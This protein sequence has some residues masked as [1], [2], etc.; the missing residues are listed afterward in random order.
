MEAHPEVGFTYGRTIKTATPSWRNHAGTADWTWR[1]MSGAEWLEFRCGEGDNCVSTPTAVARTGL[2]KRIGG[3]R[4]ELPHTGDMEM[5]LRFALHADVGIINADQ[6]FYRT[7]GQSMSKHYLGLAGFE[8]RKA[9][10]DILLAEYGDAMKGF[11]RLHASAMRRIAEDAFWRANEAFESNDPVACRDFLAFA[12]RTY[13]RL[14]PG[15]I[16]RLRLK[17]LLGP[18]T[19]SALRPLLHRVYARRGAHAGAAR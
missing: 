4:K 3:Y 11:V 14:S 7:H 16:R 17:Q 18:K 13:P 9:V 15:L 1:I 2:Q 12:R 19:W 6:A 10:F 8:Q 5:W